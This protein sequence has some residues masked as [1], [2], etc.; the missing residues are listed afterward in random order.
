M[1]QQPTTFPQPSS[2][3]KT[4]ALL[5]HILTL[6][7]GFLAP[8]IIWLVK[9]DESKFVADNAKESLNFQITIAIFYIIA[10][11][12]MFLLIG[13][14]LLPA[15]WVINLIFV[16]IATIRANEGKVYRYPINFRFIS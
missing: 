10:F 2:E 12:A 6:F 11:V 4:L 8:L 1:E 13:F 16:I 15:V 3:D 9:K 7:V 14:L 5:A